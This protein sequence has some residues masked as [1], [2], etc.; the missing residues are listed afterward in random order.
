[1]NKLTANAIEPQNVP[2]DIGGCGAKTC[3]TIAENSELYAIRADH[4]SPNKGEIG[5]SKLTISAMHS[6]SQ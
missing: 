4:V 1:L 6:T 5:S 2:D 3:V